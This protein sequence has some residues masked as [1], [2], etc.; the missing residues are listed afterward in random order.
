[1]RGVQTAMSS[2]NS[3]NLA[4]VRHATYS[5]RF[6]DVAKRVEDIGKPFFDVQALNRTILIKHT[7]RRNERSYVD[8]KTRTATKLVFPIDSEDLSSGGYSLFLEERQAYEKLENY[9]HNARG[10]AAF[11]KDLKKL[12][13]LSQLTMFDPFIVRERF[14][15]ADIEVDGVFFD[16]DSDRDAEITEQ[17]FEH[18]RQLFLGATKDPDMAER[19]ADAF[20][21]KVFTPDFA[22]TARTLNAFFG[23]QSGN[24]VQ[25]VFSWKCF[26]YQQILFDEQKFDLLADIKKLLAVAIPKHWDFEERAQIEH[27]QDRFT[28]ATHFHFTE[29]QLIFAQYNRARLDFAARGKPKLFVAFLNAAPSL[30][31]LA[32][33][34]LALLM[35]YGG[36]IRFRA[37]KDPSFT[38]FTQV[39][40]LYSDIECSLDQ[41]KP[42]KELMAI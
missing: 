17:L 1:M 15:M 20:V 35:H 18:I 36:L 5:P 29:L 24:L 28:R 26:L 16:F 14:R 13:V 41:P 38:D 19:F 3:Q 34:H 30:A 39:V 7:L 37:Q 2:R 27:I 12:E 10:I 33:E 4:W 21:N 32:G 22:E 31:M 6:F 23:L 40:E 9:L 11:Q 42:I 25:S 8:V